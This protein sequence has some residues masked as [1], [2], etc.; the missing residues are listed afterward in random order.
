[1]IICSTCY[2]LSLASVS[3]VLVSTKPST[4]QKRHEQSHSKTGKVTK[5]LLIYVASY[6]YNV[7]VIT[8]HLLSTASI[9]DV[10]TTELS[11]DVKKHKQSRNTTGRD[12]TI[13][14]HFDI[15]H[16]SFRY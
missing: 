5:I 8:C 7:F 1:M 13:I 12:D 2:L 4:D 16:H 3:D 14:C 6:S 10:L 11:S 15:F 9:G